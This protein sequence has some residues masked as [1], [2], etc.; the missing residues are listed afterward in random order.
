M[1]ESLTFMMGKFPAELPGDL[2]Y[3]RNHMWCRPGADGRNRFG[4]SAYA[5]RLM[6]DV[7]F[8]EWCLNEGDQ[9]APKQQIGN[10][11]TSKATSD[12][13]TPIPGKLA[14]FNQEVLK[15]PSAI[16]VDTYGAGWLFEIEGD[17]EATMDA[18][19]YYDYLATGWENTQRILKAQVN[20]ADWE[21]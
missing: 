5:I 10:I 11:E 16:N 9:I 1:P 2:R 4:F 17:V 12:L 7:Y 8:L 6:K 15:D 19:T 13:F 14:A 18:K 21:Q 20:T 3:C